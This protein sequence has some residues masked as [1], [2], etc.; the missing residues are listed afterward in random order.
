MSACFNLLSLPHNWSK[1]KKQLRSVNLQCHPDYE[2]SYHKS[3]VQ[4]DDSTGF[5]LCSLRR[6]HNNYL[7]RFHN[8]S[9][10]GL[11]LKS[12]TFCEYWT[13]SWFLKKIFFYQMCLFPFWY[14][15]CGKGRLVIK[16]WQEK[17]NSYKPVLFV[18]FLLLI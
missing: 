15:K 11:L 4:E 18:I 3:F 9:D 10:Q 2:F 8:A 14:K 13:L 1:N 6:N 17:S 12:F 16:G 7:N 5:C